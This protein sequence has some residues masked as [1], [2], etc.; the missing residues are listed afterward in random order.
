MDQYLHALAVE[1]IS[2]IG[3]KRRITA[4]KLLVLMHIPDGFLDAKTALL[5]GAVACAGLGVALRMAKRELEP[6]KVPLLGLGAAFLFAAQMVNFPV[7]AGTS[8]HLVGGLLIASLLGTTS[9]VIVMTS[10]LVAQCLLFAD[11]GLSALGANILNMGLAAPVV[12]MIVF[13]ALAKSTS[14][15]RRRVFAVSLGA[16]S[17]VVAAA[18]SCAGQLAWSGTVAWKLGLPAMMLSHMVIG[19]GEAAISALV[20]YS[21][22]RVRPELVEERGV[23]ASRHLGLTLLALSGAA[24]FVAPF[25]CPWPDGLEHVAERLGFASKAKESSIALWNDYQ[26]PLFGDGVLAV[27]SAGLVGALVAFVFAWILSRI[28]VRPKNPVTTQTN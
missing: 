3:L 21:I 13:R 19:L 9:A 27:F 11:G 28:L 7:A 4:S 17:S 10:V 18:T 5:S 23:A 2:H 15:L 22:A 12:G 20:Y 6:R 1:C 8:G 25:A 24:L 14:S 16:W 26:L